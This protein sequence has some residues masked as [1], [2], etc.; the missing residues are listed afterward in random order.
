M[1]DLVPA[2]PTE[3]VVIVGGAIVGSF[4][5]WELRRA[6]YT[7]PIT[8]V[9]QDPSYERSSTALSAAAIRTQFG[10][11]TCIAM[12]LHAVGLFRDLR[13]HF[14]D[15]AD[16]GYTEGGYLILGAPDEIAERCALAEM[17]RAHGADVEIL[18]VGD[19]VDRWPHFDFDG[20]GIGTFGASGEGWFDAW[21][22]LSLVRRAAR[23]AGVG[24]LHARVVDFVTTG[25]SVSGVVLASGEVLA[26][27]VCVIAAGAWSGRLAA[28]LGIELPVVPKKR[29]VFSFQAP[30]PAGGFPMLF[31]TSGVW[32]RPDGDGFIGGIQPP[33]DAD[34]DADGDFEPHHELFESVFWPHLAAR[35]PAMDRLRLRRSWAGHYEVNQLDHNGVVGPH[36]GFTNLLFA[37]GFSGH[38]VMHAPAT[39][40][41]I[42]EL[43]TAGR[44]TTI[45]LSPLGW[46]RVRDRRPM[47]EHIVY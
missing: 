17:Q 18:D 45:D 11:P 12:S 25:G 31:D 9:E 23:D 38:G 42:A 21:S 4:C 22:L 43:V 35:V 13:L 8:V 20:V 16:I 41:G 15:D 27:A 40:R 39:G 7:G 1:G 29:T 19:L 6:G 33:P 5:A 44:Y 47:V 32:T 24:Y 3:P 14:G 36:D 2:A 10:T 34:P 46:E 26:C 37:T 30:V 28:R